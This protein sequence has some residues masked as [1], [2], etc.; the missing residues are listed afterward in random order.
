MG[1]KTEPLRSLKQDGGNAALRMFASLSGAESESR[2]IGWAQT[3]RKKN[4]NP[5]MAGT[6]DNFRQNPLSYFDDTGIEIQT[7]FWP[8]E[9]GW[10]RQVVSIPF[11]LPYLSG[12]QSKE[13][14]PVLN[15]LTSGCTQ[16][17]FTSFIS[18]Q[19]RLYF[20]PWE[21]E[22]ILWL[23]GNSMYWSTLRRYTIF[24][25]HWREHFCPSLTKNL[26]VIKIK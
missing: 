15:S 18:L 1:K 3:Q 4:G 26:G 17:G 6:G 23:Q 16:A 22:I 8:S 12:L 13:K 14:N 5:Q 21:P 19:S 2:K 10:K 25:H 24:S 9:L 20:S 7:E 11:F